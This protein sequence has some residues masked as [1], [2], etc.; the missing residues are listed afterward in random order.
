MATKENVLTR[1]D[2]FIKWFLP[3]IEKFPRNYKFLIGDRLVEIQLD[4]LENLIEAYYRKGVFDYAG[5]GH[6][7]RSSAIGRCGLPADR[8]GSAPGSLFSELNR[9]AHRCLCLRFACR[10]ATTGAR[11]EVRMESLLL[12]G[13]ALSSPT[14]CRFIPA[15]SVPLCPALSRD[16]PGDMK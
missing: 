5:P 12:S 4:L 2:D 16:G 15:H 9:P 3:K 6:D 14:T 7:S 1:T 13:R 10:L 8:K 11:L